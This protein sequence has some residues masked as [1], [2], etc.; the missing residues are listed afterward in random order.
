MTRTTK[1]LS[2]VEVQKALS[3]EDPFDAELARATDMIAKNPT[4][5]K[6]YVARALLYLDDGYDEAVMRDVEKAIELNPDD[7]K[8]FAIRGLCYSSSFF[9]DDAK[10]QADFSTAMNLLAKNHSVRLASR[11]SDVKPRTELMSI[12]QQATKDIRNKKMVDDALIRRGR[13]YYDLGAATKALRDVERAIAKNTANVDAYLLRAKL[14]RADED[15]VRMKADVEMAH[16]LDTSRPE[17]YTFLAEAYFH[18]GAGLTDLALDAA[19]K[20]LAIDNDYSS[21]HLVRGQILCELG[22]RS[23]ALAEFRAALSLDPLYADAHLEFAECLEEEGL[24]PD[25]IE[26]FKAYISNADRVDVLAIIETIE[27]VDELKAAAN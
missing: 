20:A 13:A 1:T 12:I 19:D 26:E 25:A 14:C 16:R 6:A 24:I 21:A 9:D 2:T 7:P 4:D 15:D 3:Q 27:H 17:G 10:A 11:E 5:P 8:A 23:D 22:K 18:A